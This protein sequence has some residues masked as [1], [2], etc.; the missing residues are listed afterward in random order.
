LGASPIY[1][2]PTK[3]ELETG[4]GLEGLREIRRRSHRPIIA[5]GSM[6]QQTAAGAIAAGADGVAV[7]SAIVSA[8]DPEMAAREIMDQVQKGRIS[9]Q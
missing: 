3:P 8:D 5:I 9:R 4:L 7:V 1:T 6:N 2:T